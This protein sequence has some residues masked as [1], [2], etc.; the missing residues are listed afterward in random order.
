MGFAGCNRR[1]A[2]GLLGS[3]TTAEA[4]CVQ[5]EAA[6]QLACSLALIS[7]PTLAGKN[8]LSTFPTPSLGRHRFDRAAPFTIEGQ[9]PASQIVPVLLEDEAKRA[10]FSSASADRRA[11]TCL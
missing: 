5:S 10:A 1:V 7:P 11:V 6:N 4:A 8:G 2:L 3:G 9:F